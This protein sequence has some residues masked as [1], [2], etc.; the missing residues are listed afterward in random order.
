[1]FRN[2]RQGVELTV[3]TVIIFAL[4]ILIVLVLA[5][6]I[7]GGFSNWNKGTDC[8]NQGGKCVPLTGPDSGCP[9]DKPITSAYSC[10]GADAGKRCCISMGG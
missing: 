6:I 2:K 8:N 9:D 5:F 7:M 1:M 4:A 10:T 3:N